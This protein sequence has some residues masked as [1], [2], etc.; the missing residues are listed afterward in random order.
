AATRRLGAPARRAEFRRLF[1]ARAHTRRI[2]KRLHRWLAHHLGCL[3]QPAGF[4]TVGRAAA[5]S[6]GSAAFCGAYLGIEQ[7]EGGAAVV[8]VGGGRPQGKRMDLLKFITSKMENL[9]ASNEKYELDK[10]R[11]SAC[12]ES[13]L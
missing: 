10:G 5:G 3:P 13:L 4:S 12:A 11:I 1:R 7:G 6:H 2:E 9:N 8:D